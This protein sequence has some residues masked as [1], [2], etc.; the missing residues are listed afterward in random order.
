MVPDTIGPEDPRPVPRP[1]GPVKLGP[2][3]RPDRV[4]VD[5]LSPASVIPQNALLRPEIDLFTLF[6]TGPHTDYIQTSQ[7]DG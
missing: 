3:T 4:I 7:S 2:G 1:A 5:P 6:G